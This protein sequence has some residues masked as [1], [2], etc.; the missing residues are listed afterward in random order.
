MSS[1]TN[2]LIRNRKALLIRSADDIAE[3]L[4]WEFALSRDEKTAPAPTPELTAEEREV[5]SLLGDEPRTLAE[6]IAASGRDYAALSVL[7]MGLELS[8]AVRQLPGN[9]YERFR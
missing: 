5:L 4:Q 6:L 2:H 3:E 1:G 9:R 8:Q 7:L